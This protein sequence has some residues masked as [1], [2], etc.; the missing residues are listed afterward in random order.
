MAQTGGRPHCL[1]QVP[2]APSKGVGGLSGGPP[3]FFPPSLKSKGLW[4]LTVLSPNPALPLPGWIHPRFHDSNLRAFV[5]N[6][7]SPSRAGRKLRC[8]RGPGQGPGG[9]GRNPCS[10][11]SSQ[12]SLSYCPSPSGD[13]RSVWP[14]LSSFFPERNLGFF[15]FL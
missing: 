2:P 10:D 7:P 1:D 8:L 15:F 9:Q 6:H 5:T 13:E 12:S 3:P 14:D 11:P 4:N